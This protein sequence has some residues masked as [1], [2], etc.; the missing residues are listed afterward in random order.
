MTPT[1]K[2]PVKKPVK[3][4]IMSHVLV[5]AHRLLNDEEKKAVLDKFGIKAKQLPKVSIKDPV[6]KLIDDAKPGDVL[7]IKR[8]STTAGESIYYRVITYE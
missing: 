2:N 1:D 4:S 8:S 7:E 3:K 6:V 5:P